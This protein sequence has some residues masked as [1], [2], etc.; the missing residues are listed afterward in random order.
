M[1]ARVFAAMPRRFYAIDVGAGA[2]V[3]TSYLWSWVSEAAKRSGGPHWI[4]HTREQVAHHVRGLS[5][6]TI[7]TYLR[8]LRG[9]DPRSPLKLI[10]T[11]SINGR[12]GF[13]LLTPTGFEDERQASDRSITE[14]LELLVA[15]LKGD[16]GSFDPGSPLER[17]I[18]DG[19]SWIFWVASTS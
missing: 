19:R 12:H 5:D 2:L 14:K 15:R 11:M 13:W 3:M 4:A 10:D 16:P 18:D 1:T 7:T 8:R 6:R 17:R 9:E